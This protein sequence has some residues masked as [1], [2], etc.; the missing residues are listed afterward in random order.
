MATFNFTYATGTTVQQA[1]GLEIAGRIWGQYLANDV[2]L[3]I[4]VG[5][6]SSLS[7]TKTLGG[8]IPGMSAN[9]KY[10]SF[11]KELSSQANTAQEQAIADQLRGKDYNFSR[12]N[13]NGNGNGNGNDND[14]V[15]QVADRI[16]VTRANG[17]AVGVVKK[18]DKKLDGHI[19]LSALGGTTGVTWS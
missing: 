13:G 11:S 5:V 15:D 8:A 17:K 6:D 12:S 10:D 3:N 7:N 18:D 16:D 1:L 4:H 14:G 2:T 9:V 19:L